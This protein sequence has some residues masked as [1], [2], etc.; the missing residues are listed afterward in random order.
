MAIETY[1][2]IINLNVNGLNA[3]TKRHRLAE[4]IQN[5]THIYAVYKK[6][7]SDLKTHRLKLRGWKNVFHANRKQKKAGEAILISDK[8]ELKI[9]K[10]IRDKEGHYTMIKGSI[11]EEDI[12]I[13]NIYAPKIGALQYIRQTVMDINEKLTGT[14]S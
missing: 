3:P 11:Q 12:I 2:S 10:I 9:K 14:Q 8:I 4:W 6:P 13:I 1:I 7:T 5:K